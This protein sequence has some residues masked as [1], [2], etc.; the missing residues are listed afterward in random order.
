MGKEKDDF[1]VDIDPQLLAELRMM[2]DAEGRDLRTIIDEALR[3]LVSPA[4]VGEASIDI[5]E[6]LDAS[7]NKFGALY[8]KLAE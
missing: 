2:A 1:S 3:K 4:S 5:D 6:H 7:I 8:K